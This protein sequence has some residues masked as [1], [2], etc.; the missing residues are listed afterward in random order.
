[1]KLFPTDLASALVDNNAQWDIEYAY[2]C[3]LL[4]SLF[5]V[6]ISPAAINNS[7]IGSRR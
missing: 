5:P 3:H 2:T 6:W 7:P 1:M 4:V